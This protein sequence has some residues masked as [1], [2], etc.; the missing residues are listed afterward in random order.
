MSAFRTIWL[1]FDRELRARRKATV[2]VT[3]VLAVAG[4]GAMLI[5]Q[6]IG[7]GRSTPVTL[8]ADEADQL[9]G[10]LGVVFLFMA[11]ILTGQVILLGVAEE[12]S[13]RVAEVVLGAMPPRHL[14]IGKV[15]AIGAIG[16]FEVVLTGAIV[17]VAGTAFDRFDL[18]G[19][20]G[21]AVA[22]VV[23]WFVLGFVFYSTV[24]AAAGALV[25]RHQ[26]T[27][28][29]AGP[30]NVVLMVGYFVGAGSAQASSDNLALKIASLFPPL[31]PVTMPLRMI[32]GSAEVWEIGTA[33]V[34]IGVFSFGLIRFGERVYSGGLLKTGKVGW[35]A[36]W[37][38]TSV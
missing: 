11:I 13:S 17:L 36:A 1:V 21:A 19:A 10:F 12:K 27:A 5:L 24:Y 14:L 37:R 38:S 18:P 34:L 23:L 20:T 2:I 33:I 9:V 7:S 15:L 4:L 30:I 29:A 25:A 31:A 8:S 28:S 35:R 32:R 6:A 22:V 3:A 26:N 16:L